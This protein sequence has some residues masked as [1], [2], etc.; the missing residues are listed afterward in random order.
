VLPDSTAERLLHETPCPVAVVPKGYRTRA[1]SA[2]LVV[3]CADQ[4]CQGD[5]I[6]LLAAEDLASRFRPRYG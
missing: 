2:H 1:T 6:S 5:D 4:P 3:G